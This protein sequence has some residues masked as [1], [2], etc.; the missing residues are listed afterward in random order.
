MKSPCCGNGRS[1]LFGWWLCFLWKTILSRI[2]QITLVLLSLWVMI[3]YLSSHYFWGG[4]MRVCI[5]CIYTN[6]SLYHLLCNYFSSP[7][8][9]MFCFV[10]LILALWSSHFCFSRWLPLVST[11]SDTKG[12]LLEW[13]RG[14][15]V[16]IRH[17]CNSSF[18]SS[19]WIQ[20]GVCPTLADPSS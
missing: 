2:L 17:N 9:P 7:N 15:D 8:L 14:Q 20:F 11:T 4:H 13:S 1:S 19:S 16:L 5:P 12:K 6:P 10:I 3:P 18:L